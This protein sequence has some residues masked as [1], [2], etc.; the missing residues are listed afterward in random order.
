MSCLIQD[1]DVELGDIE[2]D[3]DELNELI[4]DMEDVALEEVVLDISESFKCNECTA[5]FSKEG[6][7]EN[8][9]N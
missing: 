5:T 2:D 8:H 1:M 9:M 6:F 3:T 4:Q 7:L